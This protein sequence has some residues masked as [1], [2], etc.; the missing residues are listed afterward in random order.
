SALIRVTGVI[1]K[2][3]E[4]MASIGDLVK[5]PELQENMFQLA[6]EMERA[7]LVEEV[8]ADGLALTDAEGLDAQADAEVDKVIAEITE[9]VLEG[10]VDAPT[11]V[12]E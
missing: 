7:G 2:S 4:I 11:A 12:P 9:G 6:T 8:V 1:K 3:T 10:A 5:I